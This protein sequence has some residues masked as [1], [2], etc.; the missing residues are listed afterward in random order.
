MSDWD[1]LRVRILELVGDPS[2]SR[3][4]DSLLV[5][6]GMQALRL[7]SNTLPQLMILKEV[8]TSETDEIV[9]G[10]AENLM[11]VISVGLQAVN[12]KGVQ[13]SSVAFTWSWANGLPFIRF[14]SPVAG[15]LRVIYTTG[16]SIEGLGDIPPQP[17]PLC[18]TVYSAGWQRH[19]L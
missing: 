10:E 16:Q 19:V 4:K 6:A 7:Y 15:T 12:S 18:I 11:S 2:G 8:I 14:P 9:L 5:Q 1:I 17:S 13:S 3:Y